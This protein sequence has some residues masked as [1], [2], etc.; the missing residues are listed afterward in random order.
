VGAGAVVTRDVPPYAIVAGVPAKVLRYRFDQETIDRLM[1]S[2]WWLWP[3]EKIRKELPEF[4]DAARF[5][6]KFG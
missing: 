1:K 3:D 5:G 4:M 2:E 6:A